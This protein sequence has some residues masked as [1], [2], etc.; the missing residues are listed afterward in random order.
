MTT[1]E[2]SANPLSAA[3]WIAPSYPCDSPVFV[4]SFCVDTIPEEAVLYVTGLGYFEARINGES[5]TDSMFNPPVSDY[6]RRDFANLTYPISDVFTHRI[7]YH[8]YD[9]S[10]LLKSGENILEIQCGAGWFAQCERVAEGDMAY[11]DRVQ[12]IY[13]LTFDGNTVASDGSEI[14]RETEIRESQLFLGEVI[15]ANY[16]DTEDKSVTVLKTPDAVMSEADG[17]PERVIRKIT[18]TLL[19]EREGVRI[20]DVGENISG[21]VSLRTHA[22]KGSEY[23]LRFSEEINGDG[24]LNFISTGSAYKCTSGRN[25]IMCD[26]FIA[27]G[28]IRTFM[29]RFVW[30]A[31]RYIELVGDSNALDDITVCEIHS[32]VPL[33]CE[34]DSDSEGLNFLFDAYV[35]TQ[36]SNYHGSYPC[37]CP[38]RERLG[39]TGDGQICAHTAMLMLDAKALYKKW[40]RDITD[41]Q[42]INTGHVQHTAPFGGGGGGPGGWCSAIITVPYAYF[43]QYGDEDIVREN[44]SAMKRYIE[45]TASCMENGLVVREAEGGW[46]LG[47]WCMLESGKIPPEFVNTC[48][49]VHSLRLYL[50]MSKKVT[51][52]SDTNAER[53]VDICLEALT[54]KYKSIRHIG[55]ANAYAAWVGLDSA[56]TCAKYYDELGTFDTGFLGTDILMD[57]LFKSGHGDVAYKLLSSERLGSFLYMKRNGATTLWENWNNPTCSKSHPMFGA[58]CRQLFE[59]ILGIRQNDGYNA[60]ENITVSPYLPEQMSYA[61]G[62]IVTLR[63]KITVMLKRTESGVEVMTDIPPEISATVK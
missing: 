12:C 31:F 47:D 5:L 22:K 11:S 28:S 55:A 7:Y 13:S 23:V 61:R 44:I 48:W 62:S 6:F 36:L 15:D 8:K 4:R 3:K 42:D 51:R 43:R 53:L 35:R 37:D 21:L 63:G 30:H 1:A 16:I 10:R 34:F 50:E 25:Q 14:W 40:I 46:C 20:Y 52:R 33:T 49:F 41:S 56:D 19:Y 17:A 54:E 29:P 38:H 24:T 58:C 57:V 32:D 59:G 27:D 45:F 18:P 60:F 2:K 26:R 39:Y 9:T